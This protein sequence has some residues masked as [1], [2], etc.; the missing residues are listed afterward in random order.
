MKLKELIGV[1]TIYQVNGDADIDITGISINSQNLQ[2]GELFVCIPGVPGFQEDRHKFIDDAV[3]AGA[4]ALIVERD[5]TV[6]IPAIKVP[7]ARYALAALAAHF[8]GYPSQDIKLIGVTGTNGK[9]T[10]SHMIESILT[11]AGYST[12]LMGN[13]GT[14]IG[15]SLL[16]TDINTQDPN[17]LQ[18]NLKKMKE[19]STDFCVMEVTS[20]GLHLGRVLGCDFRTAV[21]T[22]LTQDH[23]DYHGTM[24][25]YLAAKGMLFSRLG[26]SFTPDPSNRK[27]AVLNADDEASNYLNGLTAAQVITYGIKNQADVMAEDIQ[28]TSNGTKFKLHSFAGSAAMELKMVGTFNVYNALAAIATAIA[29]EIPLDN[30]RQGL[31]N[32]TSVPGRMEV[33]DEQQD[34]L[35]LADYAHTPDGL[36]KALSTLREFAGAKIIT[37]F[38]CGGDRDRTKRP[39][40][41]KLAAQYSDFIIVTSDNPRSEDPFRILKDIEQGLCEYGTS[42]DSYELIEDRRQAINRAIEMANSGDI[43]IIAG[44]GHETYQILKERTIHFDDREEAREAIRRRI[45]SM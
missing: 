10:T 30:I 19:I 32:L 12:G 25:N 24:E 21:F 2:P 4:A 43:V 6:N 17:K 13:I 34:F 42:I 11:H 37:V 39:V 9:T 45:N 16:E 33:V 44:K 27:Y 1:L 8:N 7:N 36:E 28:L 23:L 14:K 38:G 20:Q 31:A 22:N 41:G 5:V 15:P 26:N 29:E 35:V 3:K 18:A 40:M